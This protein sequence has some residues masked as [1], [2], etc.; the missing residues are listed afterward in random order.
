MIVFKWLNS[1]LEIDY[2]E[3]IVM[4]GQYPCTIT[5]Q[6]TLKVVEEKKY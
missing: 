3:L 6:P 5:I 1:G 2:I 4:D